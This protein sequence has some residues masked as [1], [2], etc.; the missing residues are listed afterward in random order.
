MAGAAVLI[1]SVEELVENISKTAI[2]TGASSFFLAVV[3][4]GL[5]LENW[6]FGVAVAIGGFLAPFE[7]ET[8]RD[9]LFL[10]LVSPLFVLLFLL[11][12]SLSRFDGFVLLVL[13][14]GIVYYLYREERKGRET[15]RVEEAEGAVE[16]LEEENREKWR[17]IGF[18]IFFLIGI[19]VGSE[20]AVREGSNIVH[21]LVLTR[22]FSA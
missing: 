7:R 20:M 14:A 8:D 19:V 2:L 6:A 10:M 12:G 21:F 9:Y 3:L 11:N 22:P 15:F 1:Y 5:D 16:E 13:F 17:Y 4:A 18:S